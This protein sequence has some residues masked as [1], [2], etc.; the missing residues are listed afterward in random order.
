MSRAQ[1][2]NQFKK[3]RTAFCSDEAFFRF[4]SKVA[5]IDGNDLV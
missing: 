5:Q 4:I 2:L 3:L 1:I